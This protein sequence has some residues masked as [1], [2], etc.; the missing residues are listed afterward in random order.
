MGARRSVAV[1]HLRLRRLGYPLLQHHPARVYR[2]QHHQTDHENVLAK[3]AFQ[4][5][6]NNTFLLRRAGRPEEI[7]C[8]ALFLAIE[9]SA[10]L[11]GKDIIVD[12]G[13]F[14][15]AP[16]SPVTALSTPRR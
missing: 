16:T 14:S 13:W 9:D 7:G 1:R 11:P 2:H 5:T 3:E 8:T 15:A 12:G 10:Y 6:T 4:Q